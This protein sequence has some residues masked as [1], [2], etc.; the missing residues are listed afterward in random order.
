MLSSLT[1]IPLEPYALEVALGFLALVSMGLLHHSKSSRLRF[2]ILGWIAFNFGTVLSVF[3]TASTMTLLDIP[4]LFVLFLSAVLTDLGTRGTLSPA[5]SLTYVAATSLSV[6]VWGCAGHLLNFQ[7]ELVFAPVGIVFGYTALSAA[8]SLMKSEDWG[9]TAAKICAA[10]LILYGTP[11][12]FVSVLAFVPVH[13]AFSFLQVIGLV[14][15]GAG[16]TA[17]VL[18]RSRKAI[19]WERDMFHLFAGVVEHD[20]QNYVQVAIGALEIL[21]ESETKNEEMVQMALDTLT[22]AET[23]I[24]RMKETSIALSQ[25]EQSLETMDL[26]NIVTKAVERIRR[27]H[28]CTESD[29]IAKMPASI[30]VLS[31]PFATELVWNIIDNAAKKDGYPIIID[32]IHKMESS[33]TLRIV[34]VAGGMSSE[35]K[36]YITSQEKDVSSVATEISLGSILIKGLA[37][38]CGA[39]ISIKDNTWDS[40]AVGTVYLLGFVTV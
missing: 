36:D 34:D 20:L 33:I 16:L 8:G 3:H 32:T 40:R 25:S 21:K 24:R 39:K 6:V 1:L 26:E 37:P 10:G 15:A 38:L 11:A 12:A 18:I 19:K 9:T 30:N 4:S 5:N 28:E 7:Y 13:F 17:L 23:F 2:W 31:N 29:L 22:S 35:L 14:V 27:E